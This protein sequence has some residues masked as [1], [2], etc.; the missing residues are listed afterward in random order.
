M[1]LWIVTAFV[2]TLG[3]SLFFT[4]RLHR[5]YAVTLAHP[6]EWWAIQSIDTMKYSRDLSREKL[7]STSFESVID[8][9]VRDIAAA[10]ATHV[11]IATPY[12]EEFLPILQR[13]V[14]AARRHDLSVWF[15]GNFSG[16]EKWFGYPA[17]TRQQH[18]DA[19]LRFISENP[20]LFADG[21]LFTACPECENGGP[22]DPRRVG[23][24]DG[25]RRFLIDEYKTATEA[26]RTARKSVSAG[27][28]SMNYDVAR[29]IMDRETTAALGGVVTIDHYI[30]DPAQLARDAASLAA[31]SGG[32]I[33][34]GEF[35]A[36]IPDI[37][38]KFTEAD[39]SDW[40]T[41]ALDALAREPSVIGVNYWVGTGGSTQL[42]DDAGTPKQGVHALKSYFSP[43]QIIG[44]VVNQYRKPIANAT[45]ATAYKTV[46]TD[47]A[48]FYAI[49][50]LPG[51]ILLTGTYKNNPVTEVR[52]EN[53][54]ADTTIIIPTASAS[55]WEGITAFFRSL[56]YR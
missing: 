49:P 10:G 41:N 19:T 32:K 34:F 51:D 14:A 50:V 27:Y 13:W 22:G 38:G 11:A 1:K 4:V 48:G 5:E 45:I 21:D 52:T 12:D 28:V 47:D 39:Q 16:W 36:P 56:F 20:D 9:Q 31:Q 8:R 44:H 24:V 55:F 42:W 18:T 53:L 17:M 30:K 6:S 35:G 37:H 2:L 26:F 33:F 15:R 43:K 3:A 46:T 54:S 23:D 40:I 25:Y 7:N 29:L